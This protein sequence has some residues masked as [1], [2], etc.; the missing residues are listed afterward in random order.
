MGNTFFWPY[1][2][3][4]NL[5]NS[6]SNT[7]HTEDD[8]QVTLDYNLTGNVNTDLYNYVTDN[9]KY[10]SNRFQISVIAADGDGNIRLMADCIKGRNRV[11]PNNEK[12]IDKQDKKC[13]LP[14]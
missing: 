2:F 4:N 8:V 6:L 3:Y 14:I 5:A 11:D 10:I 7:N 1:H 9:K 12:E 13:C